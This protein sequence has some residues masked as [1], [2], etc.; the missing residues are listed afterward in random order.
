MNGNMSARLGL[1]PRTR[2]LLWGV[3]ATLILL[4]AIAMPFTAEVNWGPED[5]VAAA[6]LLGGTGLALEVAARVL[7]DP[8]KRVLA[9]LAIIGTLLVVWAELAVGIFD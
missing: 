5:F 3:I 1:A 4:P 9:A 8:R 6:I 7:V 2:A